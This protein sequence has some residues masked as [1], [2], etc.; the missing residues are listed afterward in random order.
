M[1]LSTSISSD[2]PLIRILD[3]EESAVMQSLMSL[4]FVF[5]EGAA[6]DS[7]IVRYDGVRHWADVRSV[8]EGEDQ[9]VSY[10]R[11]QNTL[12]GFCDDNGPVQLISYH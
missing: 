7:T 11:L 3:L 9:H 2:H 1:T 5:V 10:L 8:I 6:A 4:P 12:K